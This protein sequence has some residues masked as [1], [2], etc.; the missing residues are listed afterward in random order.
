MKGIGQ[1]VSGTRGKGNR[2]PVRQDSRGPGNPSYH[3]DTHTC[4]LFLPKFP[5]A[6]ILGGGDEGHGV[7]WGGE[8]WVGTEQYPLFGSPGSQHILLNRCFDTFQ[9]PKNLG[10]A[11]AFLR[12]ELP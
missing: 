1:F 11:S 9:F 2:D 6:A 10:W 5:G 4:L 3:G 7:V 12:A 8:G